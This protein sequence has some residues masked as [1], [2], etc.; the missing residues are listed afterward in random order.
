MRRK[1][2]RKLSKKRRGSKRFRGGLLKEITLGILAWK[3]PKTLANTLESYKKN[4][5]LSLVHPVIYFQERTPEL[6]ALAASYGIEPIGTEENVGILRAFMSLI[7]HAKTKYFM[8]AECDFE[9]VNDK[10]RTETILKECIRLMT[11]NGVDLVRLRD[12]KNPGD[13]VGSRAWIPVPD[14]Q[15]EAYP[16]DQGFPHKIESLYFFDKPEDKFPGVFEV[17]NYEHKW[18]KCDSKHSWWSNHVFIT[19]VAFLKEKIF[20]ILQKRPGVGPDG[21]NDDLFAKMENLLIHNLHGHNYTVAGG[22]GLF[23]HARLDR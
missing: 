15:L 3:S 6:D 12:R 23:K 13:A 2:T 19:T 20:P 22:P 11:E 7:E 18:Y 8:F 1:Q 9:L 16:M 10:K 14:D 21:K 4:G 17:I 5:L